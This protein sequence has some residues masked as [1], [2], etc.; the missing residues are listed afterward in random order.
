MSPDHRRLV[1]HD[2]PPMPSSFVGKHY[3]VRR[4]CATARYQR[5][6]FSIHVT[7]SGDKP[8]VC[9]DANY[10]KAQR[11]PPQSSASFQGA[12]P[13]P[14][15]GGLERGGFR[16]AVVDGRVSTTEQLFPARNHAS[17]IRRIIGAARP[18]VLRHP[19]IR[20]QRTRPLDTAFR[21]CAALVLRRDDL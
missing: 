18:G 15:L 10:V 12:K 1:T 13:E 4:G 19:R 5:C 21:I 7:I 16:I 6:A 9:V 11:P 3:A 8:L 17:E 2:F 14:S 20:A